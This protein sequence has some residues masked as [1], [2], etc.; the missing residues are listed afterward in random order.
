LFDIFLSDIMILTNIFLNLNHKIQALWFKK[1]FVER[2]RT[3]W[4]K[5][6]PAR[7]REN[8]SLF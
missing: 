8:D 5:N 7:K 1:K 2:K 6:K 4:N 3:T